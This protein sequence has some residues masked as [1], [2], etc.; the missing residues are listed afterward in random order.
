M[1][2]QAWRKLDAESTGG[3]CRYAMP[4][5]SLV[6]CM[7]QAAGS[8]SEHLDQA[9][10]PSE[11]VL[12]F[13]FDLQH[14]LYLADNFG[15]HSVFESNVQRGADRL[16]SEYTLRNVVPAPFLKSRFGA[17]HAC[18]L[19]SATL[20]PRAFYEDVLGLPDETAWL[21]VQAPFQSSQLEVRV[22]SDISTR[23]TN[24]EAALAPMARIIAAQFARRPGN[25]LVFAGS[26]DYLHQ[27]AHAF[28]S[29]C[30]E[31][32]TWSQSRNMDEAAKAD[33]LAQFNPRTQGVGFA[34]LGGTFAE[35]IDLPGDRLI[36]AFIATL[37]LPQVNPSNETLKQSLEAGFKG[38]GFDYAYLYPGLCK[39]VQ[40]AGRIIR[41]PEDTGVIY[42]MDDRY[43]RPAVRRLLPGW[44]HIEQTAAAATLSAAQGQA[45]ESTR[46]APDTGRSG[47]PSRPARTR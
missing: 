3:Y 24:R 8:L 11:D 10:S 22:V 40:A 46:R 7:R 6:Q 30:P 31:V 41:S 39:V 1:L 4:P 16:S 36:G 43:N 37:G 13:Y 44:W 21:D 9:P 29:C 2:A 28:T 38:R 17:A 12:R 27:L 32:S 5:E 26:F 42:L 19:F 33:F 47:P 18:V 15:P 35:G 45:A 23:Y 14:F 25:Y 34:V 20:Q